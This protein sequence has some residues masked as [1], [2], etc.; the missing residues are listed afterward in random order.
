MGVEVA[1]G[2]FNGFLVLL[3]LWMNVDSRKATNSSQGDNIAFCSGM[4]FEAI[5]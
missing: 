3:F 2:L 4:N 5:Q 1:K